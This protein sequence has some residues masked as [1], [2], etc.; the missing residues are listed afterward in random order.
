LA[1]IDRF[2]APIAIAFLGLSGRFFYFCSAKQFKAVLG[3]S[4]QVFEWND[5]R[6][7]FVIIGTSKENSI[8]QRF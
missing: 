3:S 2:Y 4:Q 7:D 8:E 6:Y 5:T 1:K